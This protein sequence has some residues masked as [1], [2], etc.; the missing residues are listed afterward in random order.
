MA[1]LMRIGSL[2]SGIL[3]LDL[4][5]EAAFGAD[6]ELAWACEVEPYP[7]RVIRARR[8]GAELYRDVRDLASGAVV[9]PRVDLLVGGFP[10]QDISVAGLQVGIAGERSGLW[11]CFAEVIGRCRPAFVV[12]ENV[13]NLRNLGLDEVLADLHALGYAAEWQTVRALAAGALHRRSRMFI[14]AYRDVEGAPLLLHDGLT[15]AYRETFARK[16]AGL[17]SAFPCSPVIGAFDLDADVRRMR[18]AATGNAVCPPQAEP[19]FASLRG[20][21][22]RFARVD[23]VLAGRL[24]LAG[25]MRGGRIFRRPLAVPDKLAT[26]WHDAWCLEHPEV[27]AAVLPPKRSTYP[28]PSAADYGSSQ[29]GICASKPSGG[30]PS[31]STMARRGM[32]PTWPTATAQDGVNAA[33]HTTR[34]EAEGGRMHSGTTLLDAVRAAAP[35]WNTPQAHDLRG[36]RGAGSKDAGG[37]DTLTGQARLWSTPTASDNDGGAAAPLGRQGGPAL[38]DQLG[39]SK[40]DGGRFLNPE[41]VA[42]LMGFPGGWFAGTADADAQIALFG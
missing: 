5:A 41:W 23:E 28:T 34:T 13:R 32:F 38:R 11:A 36:D 7:R 33:R 2:F 20:L 10:C 17:W 22:E 9:P 6:A 21:G 30:T 25:A 26:A 19:I 24:P 12:V 35:L 3:G 1:G 29:N 18:L 39:V 31:L 4:A 15:D 27:A 14:V 8:A 16:R 37:G 40:G 42:W